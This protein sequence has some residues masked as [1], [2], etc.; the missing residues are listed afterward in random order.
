MHTKRFSIALVFVG[1]LLGSISWGSTAGASGEITEINV[2]PDC[3]RISVRADGQIGRHSLAVLAHPNR[4]VLDVEGNGLSKEPTISGTIAAGVEVRAVRKGSGARVVMNFGNRPVPEHR[5]RTVGNYLLLF[6]EGWGTP[7]GAS[8]WTP[9]ETPAVSKPKQDPV[10]TSSADLQ[11][12]SADVTNGL[13]VLKVANR[14]HPERIFKIEL[15]VDFDQLGFNTASIHP[16]SSF[17]KNSTST[18]NPS[19]SPRQ[20]AEQ[21]AGPRKAQN[22]PEED[23]KSAATAIDRSE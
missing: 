17:P 3:K 1:L 11:I 7:A 18:P 9:P 16:L 20:P 23:M 2:T 5:I 19:W 14:S 4:L 6:L 21:K 15:G 13:I 22:S 8:N 10:L 12:K